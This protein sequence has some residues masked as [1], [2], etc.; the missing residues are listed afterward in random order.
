MS[1]KLGPLTFGDR[2]ELVF[3]GREIAEQRNYSDEVAQ[4]I[5]QEVRRIIDEGYGRAKAILITYR[6]KLESIAERLIEVETIERTEFE[7]LAA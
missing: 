1:E 5:D 3:L 6:Q 2:D 4:E 7:A